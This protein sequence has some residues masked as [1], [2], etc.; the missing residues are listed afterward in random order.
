V[1]KR[2]SPADAS[3]FYELNQDPEVIRHTGDVPFAS[4]AEAESFIRSYDHLKRKEL[5][6]INMPARQPT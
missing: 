4:V 2:F 5:F 6:G 1:L 3:G